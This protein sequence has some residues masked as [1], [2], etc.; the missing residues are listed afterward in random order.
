MEHAI[1]NNTGQVYNYLEF[2]KENMND[3]DL[4]GATV[5]FEVNRSWMREQ[6][7]NASTIRLMRHVNGTWTSLSTTLVDED[8]EKL[9]FQADTPGFSIFAIAGDYIIETAGII[10]IPMDRRCYGD[11]V[12]ECDLDG[13]AWTI[14]EEC[15]FGCRA[16][17]TCNEEAP[18]QT[19]QPEDYVFYLLLAILAIIAV[20]AVVMTLLR[21]KRGRAAK[22]IEGFTTPPAK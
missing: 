22:E 2:T 18:G 6:R 16:G 21:M 19:A 12:Q 5:D 4:T 20:L 7:I 10:C 11:E 17:G 8:S 9:Y 15:G 1:G 3:T 14:I 13:L